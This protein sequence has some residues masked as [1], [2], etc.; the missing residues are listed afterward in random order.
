MRIYNSFAVFLFFAIALVVPSGFSAGP[1]LLVLG[2]PALFF[3][4]NRPQLTKSDYQMM[5]VLGLYFFVCVAMNLVHQAPWPDY[6]MP[7]RFLLVIPALLLL[8]AFPPSPFAVWSGTAIGSIGAGVYAAWQ[9]LALSYERAEGTTNPIQYG[10]ISLV[11]GMLC[12]AG[13]GWATQQRRSAFWITLLIIGAL[14]GMLGSVFTGSRGS[15]IALPFCLAVLY[16]GSTLKKGYGI[17]GLIVLAAVLI[18]LYLIP[19]TAVKER[20]TRAISETSTYLDKHQTDTSIGARLEMWRTGVLLVKERP[21]LG[22]GKE[23]YM[24]RVN[25]LIAEGKVDAVTRQHS[26][27][28]SEYLDAWVKRGVP[29]LA[30]TL[31]A[32]LIPLILFA[33]QFKTGNITTQPSALAGLVLVSAYIVFGFTQAFLTHNNG[34]MLYVFS[35]AILWA[36]SRSDAHTKI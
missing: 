6:D 21:S 11:L 30:V 28:H 32:Y 15:W 26:H 33:R 17:V 36:A 25:E 16:W 12:L 34:V 29:G 19:R 2:S 27:L 7:L 4:R 18:A 13:I 23:G 22:W 10:N 8:L 5:A 20:I 35:V 31:I 9:Y 24:N 3:I 1:V 14:C